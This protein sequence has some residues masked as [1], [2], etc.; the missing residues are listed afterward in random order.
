MILG[1]GKSRGFVIEGDISELEK[2]SFLPGSMYRKKEGVV[3][4]P[5]NISSWKILRNLNFEVIDDSAWDKL[6]ELRI[7][8]HNH[9][10]QI[11][12][13]QRLFKKTGKTD[14][15]VP[16]KTVPYSHQVQ[17]FGFGSMLKECA[18]FM[19]Q[20]TG[21]TLV[22]IA[23]IGKRYQENQVRRVLIVSPKAARRVW[24]KEFKKHAKFP[25]N[26]SI[27]EYPL[28]GI[29]VS[30]LITN[31]EMLNSQLKY[32]QKWKPQMIVLD[33]SHKIKNRKAVRTKKCI[34]LGNK[35]E[36]KLI[37]S[38]T[39]FGK[40]L[41]EVWSQFRFLNPSIFGSRF[42]EFKNLFLKMGGYM[43]YKI[44]G[45]K[46]ED[47]FAEKLHSI[48]FRVTKEECLDL[49]PLSYQK[50]YV[51]PSAQSK[52]IYEDLNIN[53]RAEI[54][55]EE[56]TADLEISKQIKLRQVVGGLVRTDSDKIASI[57]REKVSALEDVME[58]RT[59]KKTII[60]CSFTHEIRLVEGLMKKMGI[61][62]ITLEG[63]T[64]DKDSFETTF[65]EDKSI[66]VGIIQ[67]QTGG[68]ALT[69]HSADMAIFY[70]PT[71]SFIGYSQARDRLY[72][73]GQMLP[74]TVVF[75]IMEETV[76]ETI[77]EVLECN[78]QLTDEFLETRRNYKLS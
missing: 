32:I 33:E 76:D 73:I 21:K 51:T 53:F 61:K 77:V 55:G 67:V 28:R 20:G 69:L 36:F 66:E 47:L 15:P 49:P 56:V 64:K 11:K 44:T 13:A 23:L 12:K 45:Y 27:N 46:N 58:G 30:L 8:Y 65:Q 14:I 1:T 18:L 5:E 7:T 41:S 26:F 68:E 52:K 17:A 35:A 2:V 40:W 59:G 9:R 72:R 29:G 74:V 75:L 50:V 37:L 24:V 38:G 60:F 16:L 31:Y 54:D 10:K 25:W 63:K 42:T 71:F 34:Q 70:S 6:E 39:P 3:R 19:D 43:G 4:F 48:S 22:A 78:R 62:S 57:S